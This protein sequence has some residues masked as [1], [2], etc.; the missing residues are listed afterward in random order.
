MQ[1]LVSIGVYMIHRGIRIS[2]TPLIKTASLSEDM[3]PSPFLSEKEEVSFQ[4]RGAIL[5]NL[6]TLKIN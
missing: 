2:V 1:W 4:E 3:T 5:I 6:F